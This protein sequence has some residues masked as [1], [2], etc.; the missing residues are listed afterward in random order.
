MKKIALTVSYASPPTEEIDKWRLA[1]YFAAVQNAGAQIEALFLDEW[2]AKAHLVAQNFDG[3]V[4]AGGA[5]L[6]TSWYAEAP[7]EGAGL[8]LVSERRPKFEN[9]IVGAF[10]EAKKPV[11]GICYGAQFLN[12][13]RGGALIQDIELQLP[14][15]E[16]PVVHVDGN[17]HM[18][19]LSRDSQLFQI[20]GED[21]FPAPS[22]HHQAVSRVAPGAQ[23]SGFAPDG[24][25]E[26]V[27]WNLDS[28]F[29]GVQW[30]PERAPDSNATRRLMEA[31]VQAA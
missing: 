1:R 22:F 6:P 11:L 13:Y 12:V 7:L 29:L 30:H 4:L 9:E 25:A 31:F 23:I 15:R 17:E 20:I 18:V 2:E 3:V 27:E 8:D 26:A 28:F 14:E 21:E 24:V 10:L 19:R 16:N 5:D